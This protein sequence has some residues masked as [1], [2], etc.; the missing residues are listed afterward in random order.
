M[1]VMGGGRTAPNPSNEVNIYNPGTNSW[2]TG[3]PVPAFTTPRRNFAVD[4]NGTFHIGLAGGYASDGLTPLASMEIF[5]QQEG[6]PTP[7]PTTTASPTASPSCTPTYTT[8]TTTGSITGGG[9]DIGNH[10]DD[11]TT[12]VTLP[13]P[14]NAYGSP[15]SVVHAGS[16]GTLQFVAVPQPKPFYF[17][18]CIPVDPTMGGPFLNTLFPYYDD[19]RTDETAVCADCGIFTQTLG[20]A[21]NRQFVIR[22]KTTYFDHPGKGTAEFEVLLTEGSDTLSA[23]YGATLDMGL[24]GASGIQ[25]DLTVFTSF[26]CFEATLTPGLRVNYIPTGCGSPTPTP[27]ATT[28][29]TATATPTATTTASATPTATVAPPRATPTPR[30]R[31]TPA[32]RP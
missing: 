29:A 18:Q 21:P 6:T 2:T 24:E 10:C 8:A 30:P 20:T 26:S 31:P 7:T 4:T 1:L 3:A 28:T 25:K 19:M 9:T 15:T 32:P 5:C 17:D 14:V 22:W 13:F 12:M 11:C 27:T 16:N 23:I